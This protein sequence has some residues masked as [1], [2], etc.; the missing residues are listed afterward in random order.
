MERAGYLQSFLVGAARLV[1][2][3]GTHH[4]RWS[5]EKATAYMVATTGFAEARSQREVERYCV[6]IG[7][8]CSYKIGHTAWVAARAKAQ[9]VLGDKFSLPWFHGILEE[10]TMP[11]FMLEK[12]IEE[13]TAERLAAG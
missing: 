4:S 3:T 11:L 12:R 8:A 1:V 6:L 10:G 9:A 5:R 13:R 2:V 7:Q